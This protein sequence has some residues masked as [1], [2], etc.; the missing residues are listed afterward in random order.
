MS[1]VIG[2]LKGLRAFLATAASLGIAVGFVV[3]GILTGWN[4]GLVSLLGAGG[5]L[6]LAI[7][8]IHG[9]S[10]STAAVSGTFV[11]VIATMLLGTLFTDL[12]HLTGFGSEEAM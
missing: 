2:R 12:A 8:F 1:F 5:I 9:V 11:A 6:I 7:F 4:P 10:W 3:P